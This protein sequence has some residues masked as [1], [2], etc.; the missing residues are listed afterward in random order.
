MGGERETVIPAS[1]T[2]TDNKTGQIGSVRIH[3]NNG[4]VHFHDTNINVRMPEKGNLS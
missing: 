1:S 2:K 3:E 4:E